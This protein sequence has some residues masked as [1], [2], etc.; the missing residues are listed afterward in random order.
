PLRPSQKQH[1]TL[2][3]AYSLAG[4]EK[5]GQGCTPRAQS[6]TSIFS[7]NMEHAHTHRRTL[8]PPCFTVGTMHFS[9]YSSSL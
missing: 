2:N 5:A 9:L 6:N 1:Q 3:S 4:Q 7:F 8:P